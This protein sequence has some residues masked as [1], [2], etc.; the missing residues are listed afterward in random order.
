MTNRH[1]YSDI[2]CLTGKEEQSA[3]KPL[4]RWGQ[5]GTYIIWG[6]ESWTPYSFTMEASCHIFSPE[7][8]VLQYADIGQHTSSFSIGMLRNTLKRPK[9]GRVYYCQEYR[10]KSVSLCGECGSGLRQIDSS[11]DD[12]RWEGISCQVSSA[13]RPALDVS[14]QR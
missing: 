11:L 7:L 3:R 12:T 14:C 9:A 6:A 5:E 13:S 2:G 1:C 8:S 10:P 4:T